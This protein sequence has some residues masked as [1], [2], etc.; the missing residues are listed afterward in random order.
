MH[1]FFAA[2]WF[3][4]ALAP[5]AEGGAAPEVHIFVDPVRG[6]DDWM[7]S[8]EQPVR[9]ISAALARIA[10][11]VEGHPSITLEPGD[12]DSTG[13]VEMPTNSLQLAKR[14][15][16]DA[17]ILIHASRALRN[18]SARATFRWKGERRMIEATEGQWRLS[19]IQVGTGEESQIRG[20][21][22]HGPVDVLLADARFELVS[23][24]DAALWVERGARLQLTGP[25]VINQRD[26]GQESPENSY[27]G[28][29]ATDGGL[30]EFVDREHSKLVLGNGS[31]RA[32]YY[33]TIRL[34]CQTAEIT[35]HGRSNLLSVCNS[36]RIDL[37]NTMTTLVA[38]DPKNTPIGLEHDGHVL[39]ED[40]VIKIRGKNDS[41]IAL[42]KAST[43]TCN[44]LYLEGEFR[45]ALWA[46]SGSMFVGRFKGDVGRLEAR[47]CATISV[48]KIVG[49]LRGAVDAQSGGV[50]SLPDRLVSSR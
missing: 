16:P 28:V 45:T 40:A 42:Q 37:R 30:I 10:E 15:R 34:G 1:T 18:S 48:E 38:T 36:G 4:C 9:S 27:S 35:C 31:L 29:V 7:G 41:A 22:A 21:F 2:L 12:Y 23:H 33:G 46:S 13:G 50:V 20:L 14:M 3:G 39:A 8:C 25:I 43:F 47:T 5:R 26:V 6:R 24:S 17:Y 44:D 32:S 19:E 11:P 49:K